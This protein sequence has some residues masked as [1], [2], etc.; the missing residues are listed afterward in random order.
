MKEKLFLIKPEVAGNIA[1]SDFIDRSARPPI[2][3]KLRYLF[4][5]WSGDDLITSMA[6]FIVTNRLKLSLEKEELTG[7]RFEDVDIFTSEQFKELYGE[8]Q[9]PKFYWMQ[10]TGY[11]GKNDFSMSPKHRLV[12][13]SKALSLL[14]KFQLSSADLAPYEE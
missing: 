12:V 14:N 13:S 5:G 4:D 7:I 9:L 8:K 1:D 10:I 3:K 11:P 2:I 6:I